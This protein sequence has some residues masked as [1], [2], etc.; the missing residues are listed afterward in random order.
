MERKNERVQQY[1]SARVS[2]LT[3]SVQRKMVKGLQRVLAR[4]WNR[5]QVALRTVTH[6]NHWVI[7]SYQ[8]T[9][10][11]SVTLLVVSRNLQQLSS[12]CVQDCCSRRTSRIAQVECQGQARN[13]RTL[14]R[15]PLI[16]TFYRI[17][18]RLELKYFHFAQFLLN[19]HWAA[20]RPR[21]SENCEVEV[22]TWNLGQIFEIDLWMV[23]Q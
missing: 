4:C 1:K 15:K 10:E 17:G 23:G 22:R 8:S 13:T 3:G 5:T 6:L 7:G 20:H 19:A 12:F 16:N 18:H 9:E 11:N 2:A 21:Q 14:E